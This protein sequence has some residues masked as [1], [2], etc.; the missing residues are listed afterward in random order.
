MK[1]GLIRVAENLKVGWRLGIYSLKFTL[2]HKPLLLLPCLSM[3]AMLTAM[4]LLLIGLQ[5]AHSAAIIIGL[6]AGYFSCI[7]ITIFFNVMTISM[8]NSYLETKT[9]SFGEGFYTAMHRASAILLWTLITGSVG[10]LIRL[11]NVIEEKLHLPNILSTLLDVA[12][13]AATYFVVPIICFRGA[14][15]FKDLYGE[16][17]RLIK[18]VWGDGVTR[19]I[20]ASLFVSIFMIPLMFA[21]Y[22][23]SRLEN[24]TYQIELYISLGIL[25]AIVAAFANVM[26]ATLQTLFYKYADTQYTPPDLNQALMQQAVVYKAGQSITMSN[27][28]NIQVVPYNPAWPKQFRMISQQIQQALGENCIAIHHVGSTAV[29]GLWAKPIIDIIPVVKDI[30]VVKETN[31]AMQKEGYIA[32]GEFGMLFRRYFQ[33]VFPQPAANVHVYEQGSGE[34]KRLILFRDFLTQHARYRQQYADLKKQLSEKV[35]DI[36]H[37]TLAKDALI[38]EIDSQTGFNGWRMVHALTPREWETYYRLLQ[39]EPT[40]TEITNAHNQHIV[41]YQGCEVIGA[42]LLSPDPPLQMT[43]R[44]LVV[45]NSAR[46]AAAERFFVDSLKR[47]LVHNP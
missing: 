44:R 43:I 16:S 13:A 2:A 19:I 8:I 33:R 26:S 27:Q 21:F 47:W 15:T 7:Y 4:G 17:S 18:N 31:V 22:G 9:A 25:T 3:I 5:D 23:V 29:P 11:L 6:F 30:D 41:L 37:Y 12:W 34:I 36:T 39:F 38:K 46:N 35:R 10:I 32:K 20:G 1:N 40:H 42:A 24:H 45:E 28:A 14:S